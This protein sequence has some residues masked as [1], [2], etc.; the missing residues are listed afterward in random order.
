M[1]REPLQ[2]HNFNPGI[3]LLGSYSNEIINL[4]QGPSYAFYNSGESETK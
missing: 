4:C 3:L 2:V 1:S